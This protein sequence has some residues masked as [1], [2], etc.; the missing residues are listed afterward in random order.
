MVAVSDCFGRLVFRVR[1]FELKAD[2][3]IFILEFTGGVRIEERGDKRSSVFR[4]IVLVI[5][6]GL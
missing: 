5:Y 3:R 2:V 6:R 1:G 4:W